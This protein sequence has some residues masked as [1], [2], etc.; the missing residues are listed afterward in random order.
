MQRSAALVE[1]SPFHR[2]EGTDPGSAQ[3]AADQNVRLQK[4]LDVSKQANAALGDPNLANGANNNKLAELVLSDDDN[5][6]NQFYKVQLQDI[7]TPTD[8]N[9]VNLNV[10]ASQNPSA[11]NVQKTQS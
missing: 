5:K 4:S 10:T 6:D 1:I 7:V 2:R 8:L 11:S 9:E 3:F